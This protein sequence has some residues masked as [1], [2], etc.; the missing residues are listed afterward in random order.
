MKVLSKNPGDRYLSY[1][2]FGMAFELAR[3]HLLMHRSTNPD[4]PKQK[5]KTSWW[6]M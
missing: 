6:R 5:A 3:A 2:E 1:D 4:Q